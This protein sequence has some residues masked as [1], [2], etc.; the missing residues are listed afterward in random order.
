MTKNK[1]IQF[2]SMGFAKQILLEAPEIYSLLIESLEFFRGASASLR[3]LSRGFDQLR[4]EQKRTG[5]SDSIRAMHQLKSSLS[6]CKDMRR[7]LNGRHQIRSLRGEIN[8]SEGF[9]ATGRY[10]ILHFG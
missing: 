9:R 4:D 10:L 6:G 3:F 5:G 8:S 7:V 1:K 2:E